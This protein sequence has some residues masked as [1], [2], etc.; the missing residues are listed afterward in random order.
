MTGRTKVRKLTDCNVEGRAA[1]TKD[2]IENTSESEKATRTV[3]HRLRVAAG[4]DLA[5]TARGVAARSDRWS[6][7]T[8]LVHRW[9]GHSREGEAEDCEDYWK[10]H[11]DDSLCEYSRVYRDEDD[12]MNGRV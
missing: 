3:A 6:T 11:F 1:A 8:L 12:I 9:H 5:I 2:A 7:T 4:D 10:L